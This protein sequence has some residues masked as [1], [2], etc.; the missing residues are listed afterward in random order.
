MCPG[1][2]D[3]F[4]PNT[5]IKVPYESLFILEYIGQEKWC[6]AYYGIF[7]QAFPSALVL[8]VLWRV[9]SKFNKSGF[10]AAWRGI[11]S[12]TMQGLLLR[13]CGEPVF[14]QGTQLALR[15]SD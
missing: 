4:L 8:M 6:Q 15:E 3:F 5:S 12:L 9:G 14:T 1:V 10:G 2:T 11:H 13:R 7:K